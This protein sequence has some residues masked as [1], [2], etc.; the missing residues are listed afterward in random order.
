MYL[1]YVRREKTVDG[2][3]ITQKYYRLTESYRDSNGKTRQHML[4]ALGYLPDLPTFGQREMYL[5]CLNSLVLRGEYIICEDNSV[6]AKVS[7]TYKELKSRG[8]VDKI[9]TNDRDVAK[10]E[11][12]REEHGRKCG[13]VTSENFFGQKITNARSVGMENV[14]M[15]I[16]EK[17]G[18]ERCLLEH[19]FSRKEARLAVVQVAARV[20]FPCSEYRTAKYLRDE[21]SLCEMAGV[22]GSKITKD[23]LYGSAKRLYG[24]HR[25]IEDYLHD[26]VVNMFDI[27]EKIYLLDLSNS[28]F[29]GRYTTSVVFLG[30]A[31]SCGHQEQRA[32]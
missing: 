4:L 29:E 12:A 1:K 21:S 23:V 27:K 24:I 6:S 5:R 19:G 28:Y 8:L 13:Y 15:S 3:T 20:V 9:I 17:H 14:C 30:H 10:A 16:L 18:L 11:K 31:L 26:R 25:Q 32:M 7:E 22:D 2:R